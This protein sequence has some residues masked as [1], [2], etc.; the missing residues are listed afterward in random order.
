M[1]LRQQL[2][3]RYRSLGLSGDQLAVVSAMTLGDRS[4]LSS[5]LKDDYS[6]SGGAHILALSGM[7]LGIIYMVLTLVL[8]VR[9]HRN[10]WRF[11]FSSMLLMAAI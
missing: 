4:M 5:A 3:A 8:G 6:I 11:F 7:H 2:T 9:R 1:Q 10:S